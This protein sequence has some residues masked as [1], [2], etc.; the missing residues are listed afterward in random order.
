M[1]RILDIGIK[2]WEPIKQSP[3]S[4]NGE[5]TIHHDD[6]AIE[7]W[8]CTAGKVISHGDITSPLRG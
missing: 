3:I 4:T 1:I 8:S 2:F 5:S 7:Q 6:R